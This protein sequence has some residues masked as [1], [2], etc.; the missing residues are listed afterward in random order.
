MKTPI[1][2]C[3]GCREKDAPANLVRFVLR[4][5]VLR[6]DETKSAAGRGGWLHERDD[7]LAAAIRRGGFARS[8]RTKVDASG[9]AQGG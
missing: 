6:R 1:R 7:C 5:G 2:T 9:L 8:F 3:V 4:D